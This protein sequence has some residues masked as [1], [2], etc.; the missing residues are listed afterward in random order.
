MTSVALC[1]ERTGLGIGDGYFRG[2]LGDRK[3]HGAL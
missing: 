1:F 3:S 2:V